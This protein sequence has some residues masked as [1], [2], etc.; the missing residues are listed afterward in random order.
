MKR[1]FYLLCFMLPFGSQAAP[2]PLEYIN[3]PGGKTVYYI[4]ADHSNKA[5]EEESFGGDSIVAMDSK[6][7]KKTTLLKEQI[8]EESEK[9]LFSFFNLQSSIDGKTLYF[10]TPT[11]ATSA[12]VHSLDIASRKAKFITD[13]SLLCVIAN[14]QY[15]NHL[16]ITQHRYFIPLGSY[17]HY[18]LYDQSGKLVGLVADGELTEPE[19]L[20]KCQSLG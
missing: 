15:Q 12:A 5:D 1:Y 10:Q 2:Q 13:G 20:K 14:G 4:M 17:D 6:S 18:Y 11:W 7:G 8:N 3:A 19:L 16:L 9:N